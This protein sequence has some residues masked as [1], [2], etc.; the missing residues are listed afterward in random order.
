MINL[1]IETCILYRELFVCEKDYVAVDTANKGS[2][3]LVCVAPAV[4]VIDVHSMP[5]CKAIRLHRRAS[6]CS[7]CLYLC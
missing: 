3:I 7:F 4:A 2:T 5:N 1:P 6:M